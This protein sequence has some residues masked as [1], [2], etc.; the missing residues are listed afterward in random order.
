[1]PDS[2]RHRLRVEG[3]TLAAAGLAGAAI[4]LGD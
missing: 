1:M 2:Y 4:V 3:L